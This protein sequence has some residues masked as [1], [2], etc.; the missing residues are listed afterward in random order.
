MPV[1]LGHECPIHHEK[2]EAQSAAV[3]AVQSDIF[4]AQSEPVEI[5]DWFTQA[6][7]TRDGPI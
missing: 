5:A 1:A 3:A 2:A 6:S 4:D 7:E